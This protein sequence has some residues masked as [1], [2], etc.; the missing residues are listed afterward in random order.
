VLREEVSLSLFPADRER[1][2]RY[3]AAGCPAQT[4]SVLSDAHIFWWDTC[5][6]EDADFA[7]VNRNGNFARVIQR[8][9]IWEVYKNLGRAGQ[10]FTP[11]GWEKLSL[12]GPCLREI[13]QKM[14]LP[15]RNEERLTFLPRELTPKGRRRLICRDQLFTLISKMDDGVFHL[16]LGGVQSPAFPGKPWESQAAVD[17]AVARC[18]DVDAPKSAEQ[19]LAQVQVQQ[20][21]LVAEDAL[22]DMWGMF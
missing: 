4:E 7:I 14:W 3:V 8:G 15:S 17:W 1:L 18:G 2:E 21:A 10:C 6:A 11:E 13:A 9:G 5:G 16:E 19:V 22:G 12:S 20:A